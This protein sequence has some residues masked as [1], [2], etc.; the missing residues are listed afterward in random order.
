[1]WE[2]E[3]ISYENDTPHVE[4]NTKFRNFEKTISKN[5]SPLFF[6]KIWHV[7]NTYV[8]SHESTG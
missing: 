7:K 4:T 3:T 2:N 8:S 1:M 5:P 6:L